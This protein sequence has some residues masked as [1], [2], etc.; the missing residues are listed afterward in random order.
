[1]ALK[2]TS[3]QGTRRSQT[4]KEGSA[5]GY[6]STWPAH[7]TSGIIDDWKS[8]FNREKIRIHGCD[9][10][11]SGPPLGKPRCLQLLEEHLRS[12]LQD[13]NPDLPKAHER[14]LQ[15][16]RD[17][18]EDFIE[19][20]S[21][22]KPL[23]SSIKNEYETALG[24]LRDQIRELEPM[25]ARL[26]ILSEESD[27]RVMALRK[28]EKEEVK[29]L[30]EECRSL[31]KVIDTMKEEQLCLQAQVSCL[32]KDLRDQYLAYR[33]ERDA[34]S[35]LIDEMTTEKM[36]DHHNHHEEED[37]LKL[38]LELKV[39]KEDM[40]QV[41][42]ELNKLQADY[43]CVVPRRDWD[44]LE[45]AHQEKQTTL[46][47]L[48]KDHEEL[49]AQHEVLVEEHRQALQERDDL[50]AQLEGNRA[51]TPRPDWDKCADL[52]GGQDRWA[53]IS[54]DLSSQQLLELVLT[55]LGKSVPDEQ[56]PEVV[57]PLVST[58]SIDDDMPDCL[59]YEGAFQ[60]MTLQRVD[61][62]R[63]IKDVWKEKVTED[64]KN[65]QQSN[66]AEFLRGYLER[67]HGER[68]GNWAYNLLQT[69]QQHRDDD[70]IGLF[71]DIIT[72]KVDEN[73]YHG[74]THML[75]HLLKV[76]ISSDAAESGILTNREFSGALKTAFPLKEE[77]DIEE[78]VTAAQME[79]GTSDGNISY[80]AL[81]TEDSDGKHRHFLS[82]VK[83]QRRGERRR[84]ITHL[85]NEL[86]EKGTVEMGDL[87]MAFK[88]IDPNLDQAVLEQYLGLAFPTLPDQPEQTH[89]PINADLAMQRL[90]VADVNRAGPPPRL[91]DPE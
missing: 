85:R 61:A 84:Y 69:C 48:K 71:Y 24:L 87:R 27:L 38:K 64:E 34:R 56:E 86:G 66:L 29:K 53:E 6:L 25:R 37:I 89:A 30:E 68:A 76:L 16:Y 40:A 28:E 54:A 3:Y 47:V 22:Y 88:N 42:V 90:L 39:C 74:Q 70:I 36:R 35:L 2:K 26:A 55:E 32:E 51:H 62:V 65:E 60:R 4:S 18:F 49:K 19:A 20:F 63:I 77:Q 23:L 12:E 17:V 14:K 91:Q 43:T 72:G 59:L 41:E 9:D 57:L 75:S 80:Q 81:Y 52:M 58:Q 83:E 15:V 67:Q 13:W 21:A 33:H 10:G 79:L 7:M 82:L 78:L 8:C 50:Q 44:E 45:L 11:R 46:E 1:M 31:N 5:P 73:V